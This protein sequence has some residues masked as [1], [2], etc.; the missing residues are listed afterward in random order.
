MTPDKTPQ[1]AYW[2]DHTQAA[3]ARRTVEDSGWMWSVRK[4]VWRNTWKSGETFDATPKMCGH[5]FP[6]KVQKSWGG[7]VEG[8]GVG[9][10]H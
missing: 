9:G 6:P 5:Y 10:A 1:Q 2:G 7:K 8:I 4:A 3:G